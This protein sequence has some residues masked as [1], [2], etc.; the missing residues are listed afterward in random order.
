MFF[1][2]RTRAEKGIVRQIEA[3]SVVW[4]LIDN[5]KLANQITWLAAVNL[6]GKKKKKLTNN[7]VSMVT[8]LLTSRYF[9]YFFFPSFTIIFT[10]LHIWIPLARVQVFF[11]LL[12]EYNVH[13]PM[14]NCGFWASWLPTRAAPRR[15]CHLEG[16]SPP[17]MESHSNNQLLWWEGYM[18]AHSSTYARK[19]L[20]HLRWVH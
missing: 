5:G 13:H 18:S 16:L 2:F 14:S 19:V 10:S 4:T 3:S 7:K 20:S 15:Q 11:C 12:I 1:F 17:D 9:F 8:F 6:C